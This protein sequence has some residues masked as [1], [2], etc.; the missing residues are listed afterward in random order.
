MTCPNCGAS[1]PAGKKFCS[2][3]G[4]KLSL[5]CPNCGA[6]LEGNER[7]CGECGTPL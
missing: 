6:P 4:T 3:C 2:Q 7:F 1:N 5:A